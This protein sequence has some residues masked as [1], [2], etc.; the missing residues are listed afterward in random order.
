VISLLLL[1][2]LLFSAARAGEPASGT[3]FFE[4][5]HYWIE[6]ALSAS[7][8]GPPPADPSAYLVRDIDGGES[9]RPSRVVLSEDGTV[10][11]LSSSRIRGSRCYEIGVT[12]GQGDSLRIG[13]VCDPFIDPSEE[14]PCASRRLFRRWIAP[15]FARRG[16]AYRVDALACRYE[17]AGERETLDIDIRPRV[18]TAW[19]TVAGGLSWDATSWGGKS[20]RRPVDRRR[21]ALSLERRF[22]TGPLLFGLEASLRHERSRFAPADSVRRGHALCGL[23]RLRL[24][25]FF[26]ASNRWCVSVL[27]GVDVS[28]GYIRYREKRGSGDVAAS[29]EVTP[30]ASGA[31]VWTFL[32]GFQLACRI[33]SFWPS[34]SG[35]RFEAF[36][37]LRF[38]LLLRDALGKPPGSPWHPD[39]ELAFD[40]GRRPPL[41]ERERRVA[42]GFTFDLF[43]F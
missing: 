10:A 34:S 25:R 33:E 13:P 35:E 41:F 30:V 23:C 24:D 37:E 26:A 43:P 5:G 1:P 7:A 4:R 18:E 19:W 15:A 17:F 16:E 6:I 21:I 3:L 12:T 40:D 29:N 38:R 14:I 27:K 39:L 31:F 42:V 36:R 22:R 32:Y 11:V 28:F 9:F 20:G 2:L 8:N